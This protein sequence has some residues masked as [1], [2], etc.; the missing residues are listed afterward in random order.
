MLLQTARLGEITP[1]IVE[2]AL[3]KRTRL[4]ALASAHYFSG[5]RIDSRRS[6]HFAQSGMS[7]FRLMRI[8]TL[9]A[10]PDPVKTCRF[11]QRRRAKM[12]ARSIGC[13]NSFCQKERPICLRP[14]IIGGWNVESPNFI[15]QREIRYANGGRKFEPGGYNYVPI[16]GMQGGDCAPC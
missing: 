5:Y 6:A 1:E 15:A 4:V 14:M 13:W 2:N 12:D 9:G 11:S 7:C 8:Q 16:A 3:T 10:F